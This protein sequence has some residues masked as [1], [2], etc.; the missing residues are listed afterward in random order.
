[1]RLTKIGMRRQRRHAKLIDAFYVGSI[2]WKEFN[3]NWMT[4]SMIDASLDIR[5][6]RFG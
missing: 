4:I 5:A 6:L 2:I 1:M 3:E